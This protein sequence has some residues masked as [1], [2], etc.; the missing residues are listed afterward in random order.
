MNLGICYNALD[1]LELLE[2]SASVMRP[3]ASYIGV[4]YQTTSNLGLPIKEDPTPL[5]KD[6][7]KRGIIDEA[8]LYTPTPQLGPHGNEI[9]KRQLGHL[10]CLRKSCDWTMSM[11]LDE[12]YV[13][14]DLSQ[15]L[16]RAE[17]E[18][19]CSI[20]SQMQTYYRK[21]TLK[22]TPPEEYYVAVAY[23]VMNRNY[24]P[25]TNVPVLV[26]PTR[27][28]QVQKPLI[29]KREELEMHH[30]SYIRKDML[31]KLESS[32]STNDF[33]NRINITQSDFILNLLIIQ[34]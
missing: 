29:C 21:P 33:K 32:S 8:I 25:N 20:F 23:K 16:Q 18:G 7:L 2:A 3:L 15:Q 9:K 13:I 4:L 27:K 19:Y 6:L 17:A 24:S 26:D 28:M 22:L 31:A 34:L 1:G 5:L 14:K 12:F 11:D 10:M 30:M